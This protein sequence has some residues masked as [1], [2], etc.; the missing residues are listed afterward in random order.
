M[1]NVIWRSAL[2]WLPFLATL[3][4]PWVWL[5]ARMIDGWRRSKVVLSL[6][7]LLLS[8]MMVAVAFATFAS[9]WENLMGTPMFLVEE[10]AHSPL[11]ARVSYELF[12]R[13]WGLLPTNDLVQGMIYS[14]PALLVPLMRLSHFR[15]RH[16]DALAFRYAAFNVAYFWMAV[17]ATGP[18]LIVT[19]YVRL[20][21]CALLLLAHWFVR[22]TAVWSAKMWPTPSSSF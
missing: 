5:A 17:V 11:W 4:L 15:R 21:S 6:S 1:M 20:G 19:T 14:L 7:Y 13:F 16:Q 12:D 8:W 18:T 10:V 2:F 22:P 9:G 3:S